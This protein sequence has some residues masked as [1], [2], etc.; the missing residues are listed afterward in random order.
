[1]KARAEVFVE[2]LLLTGG[3]L[4][5]VGAFVDALGSLV[6]LEG[7]LVLFNR[8]DVTLRRGFRSVK[9]LVTTRCRTSAE[10]AC[11]MHMIAKERMR[12]A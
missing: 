12:Q 4:G 3:L 10:S 5:G 6:D 8:L 1:M 2:A 9:C 11:K 7:E